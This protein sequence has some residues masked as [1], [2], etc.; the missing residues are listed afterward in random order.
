M[1]FVAY[2]SQDYATS[3]GCAATVSVIAAALRFANPSAFFPLALFC[4]FDELVQIVSD[5][6][7]ASPRKNTATLL[8]YV[9][10]IRRFAR[11]ASNPVNSL[12][13]FIQDLPLELF[14]RLTANTGRKCAGRLL[15]W[16]RRK[17]PRKFL[18]KDILICPRDDDQH[19]SFSA[20]RCD[21]ALCESP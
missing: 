14:D 5:C 17:E 18:Y 20:S 10:F 8:Q 3:A 9:T 11:R 1:L 6:V 13:S 21:S 4:D 19:C 2:W 16:G 7:A 12:F 15:H